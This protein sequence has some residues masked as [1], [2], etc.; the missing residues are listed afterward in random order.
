MVVRGLEAL[1]GWTFVKRGQ[2]HTS[3]VPR[4]RLLIGSTASLRVIRRRRGDGPCQTAMWCHNIQNA[5]DFLSRCPVCFST[6][7]CN[8]GSSD[9]HNVCL[10]TK[11]ARYSK[12]LGD[13]E[14]TTARANRHAHEARVEHEHVTN[15]K[16]DGVT[17]RAPTESSLLPTT[18]HETQPGVNNI[19]R[20]CMNAPESPRAADHSCDLRKRNAHPSKT[21]SSSAW[22]LLSCCAVAAS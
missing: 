9:L 12:P 19:Q 16:D 10:Q 2:L 8:E 13:G 5:S 22:C 15:P 21:A 17:V 4:H 6:P 1:G 7:A 20:V 14:A 11:H 18:T 3:S